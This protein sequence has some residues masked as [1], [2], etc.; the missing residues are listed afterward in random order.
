MFRII[1]AA[2]FLLS[3]CGGELFAGPNVTL[4]K[5][6]SGVKVLIGDDV[7][8]VYRTEKERKKPFFYPVVAA[9]GYELL[10]QATKN[11]PADAEAR[12]IIVV[13]DKAALSTGEAVPFG[14][15]LSVEKVD[16]NKV[17]IAGK[18]AWLNRT[19]I[20]PIASTIVR[21]INDDPNASKD[22]KSPK[23]YDH[24]HHK[25][26]WF[27]VDE[28]ND[29]KFWAE[30][31][32]IVVTSLEIIKPSGETATLKVVSEWRDKDGKALLEEHTLI[33]I[34]NQRL[35][36]YDATLK[37][38]V[39]NLHIG[40]TKEG[41]FAIRFADSMPE[42]VARGPVI[43]SDG[44][45]GTKEAWGKP[46]RWIDYVGPVLGKDYGA[47]I[48]DSSNNPWKSRYHV[49]DY[50]LFSVNPFGDGAYTEKMPE[51]LPVHS[52]NLKKGESLKFQYGVWVHTGIVEPKE[53]DNVYN[54]F[55][56]L[57][58]AK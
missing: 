38:A 17:L 33:N 29:V 1:M 32:N 30:D 56:S 43:N 11:E 25:G 49:R 16:G 50:G 28:I 13:S 39:D 21:V 22:R 8:T 3:Y 15:V 36:S 14:T 54:Q 48:M 46:A 23:F 4:K 24:P 26:I 2:A 19:D 47:T 5:E 10:T 55:I 57:D 7:F 31:S 40:D 45:K 18:N 35:I 53:I 20:A 27:A 9:G 12:K 6:E 41:L 52:R 42:K 58:S 44:L 34:T 51:R 37:A